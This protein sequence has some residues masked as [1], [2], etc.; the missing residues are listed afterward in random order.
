MKSPLR[1]A[2]SGAP[3]EKFSAMAA[4]LGFVPDCLRTI[5]E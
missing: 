5:P 3:E 1:A 2:A 4:N